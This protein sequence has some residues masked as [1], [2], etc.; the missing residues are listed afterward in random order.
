MKENITVQ[1]LLRA[2]SPSGSGPKA[3]SVMQITYDAALSSYVPD[4]EMHSFGRRRAAMTWSSDRTGV[5]L[6]AILATF[7]VMSWI[8]V[9]S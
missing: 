2:L 3:Q 6:Y 9:P 7:F 4:N 8:Y 1:A 5:L